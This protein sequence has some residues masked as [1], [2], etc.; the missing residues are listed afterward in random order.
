MSSVVVVA[1]PKPGQRP[2]RATRTRWVVAA[3]VVL[4]PLL[5]M[6]EFAFENPPDSNPVRVA[7]WLEDPGRVG[8]SMAAGLLAVPFLLGGVAVL[9]ALTRLQ[10]PVFAWSAGALM[11]CAMVGLAAIHG[12]ELSAFAAAHSGH[13]AVAVSILEGGALGLPGIVMLL[14]FLGGAAFGTLALVGAIWRSPWVPRPVAA[15]TL[16]FAVLDFAV[17]SPVVSHLVNLI[18]FTIIA[19]AVVTGYSRSA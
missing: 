7:K 14:I 18:G 8:L 6:V 19:Y 2:F 5:Q 12:Y 11:T 4:G 17:G 10:A 3:V 15:F 9:V 13:P 16:A 1:A